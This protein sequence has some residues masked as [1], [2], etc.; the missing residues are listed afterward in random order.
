MA[1]PFIFRQRPLPYSLRSRASSRI[2]VP[3]AIVDLRDVA[4]DLVGHRAPLCLT[5][6]ER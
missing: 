2:L 4:D 5:S 3:T 6:T 1:T